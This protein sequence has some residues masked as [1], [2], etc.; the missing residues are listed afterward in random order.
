MNGLLKC[1]LAI[2]LVWAMPVFA[3]LSAEQRLR[4]ALVARGYTI[5]FD[6]GRNRFLF[7][8][9]QLAQVGEGDL[10][11]WFARKRPTWARCAELRAKSK[12][13]QA[14][15]SRARGANRLRMETGPSGAKHQAEST[16]A[17]FAEN[18]LSGWRVLDSVEVLEKGVY[19]VSV[20]VLWSPELEAAGRAAR[21][22]RLSP[23]ATWNTDCETWLAAQDLSLWTNTRVFQDVTGFPHLL[24]V[25]SSVLAD[26][27]SHRVNAA[28]M[29]ADMKARGSLLLGLY[30]DAEVGRY[31]A[32][33]ISSDSAR[34]SGFDTESAFMSL[35]NVEVKGKNVVG[36]MP[37]YERVVEHPLVK[38][39]VLVVVYGVRPQ[40]A[41][42]RFAGDSVSAPRASG[43]S[44]VGV[45]IF[46]PNTGKFEGRAP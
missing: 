33:R 3:R 31:A 11:A 36:M 10:G 40:I 6:E 8:G 44:S 16:F 7:L 25:G 12:L 35:A 21:E 43:D 1:V 4:D 5:G 38:Q 42:G 29:E 17:L 20:A 46:N 39:K 19:E 41:A 2:S 14:L 13:L 45:M 18:E 24:G 26:E 22:G 37:I 23:S 34:G 28:R 9:R 15:H 32:S 27:N 30:G